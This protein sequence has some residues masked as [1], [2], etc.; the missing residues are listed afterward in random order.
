[1][2]TA[3]YRVTPDGY[4]MYCTIALFPTKKNLSD[5]LYVVPQ[6]YD[7]DT[8]L[9]YWIGTQ[10]QLLRSNKLLVEGRVSESSLSSNL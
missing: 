1:M 6:N 3:V 9:G 5:R 4:V 10:R 2:F 7:K 8:Q